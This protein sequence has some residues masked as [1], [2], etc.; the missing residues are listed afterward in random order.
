MDKMKQ[1]KPSTHPARLTS[2]DALRGFNMFWIIGAQNIALGLYE[3]DA[4]ASGSLANQLTHAGWNGFHFYDAIF[5]MFVFLVGVSAYLSMQAALARGEAAKKTLRRIVRRTLFL[6]LLGVLYNGGFNQGMGLADIRLTGVL[7]R[8]AVC[9]LATALLAWKTG[10][11]VTGGIAAGIIVG[12]YLLMRFVPVPGYGAGDWSIPGNLA[13]YLDARFLPGQAYL[14]TWDPEGL[15]ST[16]PAIATCLLGSLAG[17]W[18]RGQKHSAGR[19][20]AF[21]ALCGLAGIAMGLALNPF[22]P[23]NK[24]LWTST[25]VLLTGGISAVMLA[26]FHWLI[27]IRGGRV[28][29]FPFMVI[30]MN[31]ITIYLA[32]RFINFDF[33]ARALAGG[34]IA[35]LF[36]PGREL[37]LA[38]VQLMVEWYFLHWLYKRKIFLRL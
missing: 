36:G 21:L 38:I 5:P 11:R 6:F 3:L 17:Q 23:I 13:H 10:P 19:N 16:I 24:S 4:P 8:I 32:V 18:L 9:Y 14:G 7:Q 37:F 15:L 25:Y 12:Y 28:W 29:A 1:E 30:G 26:A 33:L 31:S 35:G 22:F 20:S 34:E 2:V 27:D